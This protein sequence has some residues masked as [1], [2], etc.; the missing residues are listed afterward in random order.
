MRDDENKCRAISRRG[1]SSAFPAAG[2][3]A[4][5]AL[6]DI[7]WSVSPQIED[8]AEDAIALDL[9]GL[10]H[11]FRSEEEIAA[12]LVQRSSGC[13]LLPNV[14]IASNIETALL[15]RAALPASP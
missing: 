4:H 7:G 6:L 8:T 10:D 13:G 2:K 5:A 12:H 1:D 9:F 11:L 15:A 3:T 14:A